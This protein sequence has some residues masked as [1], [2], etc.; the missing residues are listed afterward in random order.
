M[1]I[2]AGGIEMSSLPPQ[3]KSRKKIEI[4]VKIFLKLIEHIVFI[5]NYFSPNLKLNIKLSNFKTL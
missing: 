3:F 5:L 1:L 2:E 4:D